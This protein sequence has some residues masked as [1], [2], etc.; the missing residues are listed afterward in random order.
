MGIDA[1]WHARRPGLIPPVL[2]RAAVEKAKALCA[3]LTLTMSED[4]GEYG[5]EADVDCADYGPIS[6]YQP[7]E[8]ED[9]FSI[10]VSTNRGVSYEDFD[11]IFAVADA[12]AKS[13]GCGYDDDS[14]LDEIRAERE[15]KEMAKSTVEVRSVRVEVGLTGSVE[16]PPRVVA[17]EGRPLAVLRGDQVEQLE[18][19]IFRA[20]AWAIE[21]SPRGEGRPTVDDLVLALS[22]RAEEV[23]R[24]T[25]NSVHLRCREADLTTRLRVRHEYVDLFFWPEVEIELAHALRLNDELLLVS[26]L[27]LDSEEDWLL[28]SSRPRQGMTEEALRAWFDEFVADV[29]RLLNAAEAAAE[30]EGEEDEGEEDEGEEDEGEE[31]EGEEDEGEEDENG[32]DEEDGEDG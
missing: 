29:E 7:E 27:A 15:Q 1:G 11:V 24:P 32:E 26:A 21:S 10:L 30:D 19:S 20:L 13:L 28:R 23:E 6:L 14:A 22:S 18:Q 3:P 17:L 8:E 16:H 31:D 4:F 5:G 2:V 12:I 25:E 9:T